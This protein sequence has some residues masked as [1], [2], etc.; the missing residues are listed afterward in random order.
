MFIST[1][2]TDVRISSRIRSS[3]VRPSWKR[4]TNIPWMYMRFQRCLMCMGRV[5]QMLWSTVMDTSSYNK[6][7]CLLSVFMK[8]LS[9]NVRHFSA[10][11]AYLLT[12][13]ITYLHTPWSS[14]SWKAITFSA[15]QEIPR[16]LRNPKVHYRIHKCPPP[17]SIMSQFDTIH[18][19]TSHFL[20]IHLNI[21][22]P[23]MPGSS[24]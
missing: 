10:T 9:P 11:L 23:S 4:Q 13:W 8:L 12:Y 17:V 20:K 21:I 2:Q 15:T 1:A 5:V 24:K 19:P 18:T 3:N 16:V 7:V 6:I 14:P 22:L